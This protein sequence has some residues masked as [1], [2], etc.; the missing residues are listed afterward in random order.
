MPLTHNPSRESG[1][2]LTISAGYTR[3]YAVNFAGESGFDPD[4]EFLTARSAQVARGAAVWAGHR[5]AEIF[6]SKR[7]A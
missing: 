5:L 3:P 6:N 4:N 2:V 1:D 7:G